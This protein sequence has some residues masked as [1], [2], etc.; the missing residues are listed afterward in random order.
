MITNV[1]FCYDL[2]REKDIENLKQGGLCFFEILCYNSF[3]AT[4]WQQFIRK[5]MEIM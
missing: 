1:C 3:M 2:V 5:P 4:F